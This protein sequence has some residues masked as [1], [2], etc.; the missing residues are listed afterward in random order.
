M[1][2]RNSRR[3]FWGV[4]WMSLATLVLWGACLLFPL[5]WSGQPGPAPTLAQRAGSAKT[6]APRTPEPAPMTV[7]A[8]GPEVESSG[9][10][11]KHPSVIPGRSLTEFQS[12]PPLASGDYLPLEFSFPSGGTVHGSRGRPP[13]EMGG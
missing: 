4:G 9:D 8:L 5:G 11:F 10:G 13:P 2:F 12:A 3:S 6:R 7:Q 1:P